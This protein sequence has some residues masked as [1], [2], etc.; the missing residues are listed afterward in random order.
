MSSE[1]KNIEEYEN[2]AVATIAGVGPIK[3]LLAICGKI[4]DKVLIKMDSKNIIV[5][6]L[7]KNSRGK[8]GIMVVGVI[9][10]RKILRYEFNEGDDKVVKFNVSPGD[11][12]NSLGD[13]KSTSVMHLFLPNSLPV[14][15]V[16]RA[17]TK[18]GMVASNG[19]TKVSTHFSSELP[20]PISIDYPKEPVAK[21]TLS[22]FSEV[23][24]RV[25]KT[26]NVNYLAFKIYPFGIEIQG[27]AS[28]QFSNDFIISEP[29]GDISVTFEDLEEEELLD[30]NFLSLDISDDESN[31]DESSCST[32][33]HSE[34]VRE[35]PS[36]ILILEETPCSADIVRL[37]KSRAADFNKINSVCS[38]SATVSFFYKRGYPLKIT[39][40]WGNIG[41]Y[42]IYLD[43]ST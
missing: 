26:P 42:N 25:T 36:E 29:I 32:G 5:Q 22:F 16:A 20:K 28:D 9:K 11:L 1:S 3:A 43:S 15:L 18:S 8:V 39:S 35:A 30:D 31:Q 12:S 19:G 23:L 21:A 14:S 33:S 13:N 2:I 34:S 38:I 17:G 10:S 40:D 7:K 27:H 4:S 37:E 41:Y 6:A 24:Q